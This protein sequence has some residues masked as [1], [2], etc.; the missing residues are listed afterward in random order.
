MKAVITGGAGFIGGHLAERLVSE[1]LDVHVI[2]DFSSGFRSN[3]G[4]VESK[5][6]L[7]SGSILDG[8]LLS[9]AMDGAGAVFHLA[10]IAS[11]PQCTEHPV[12]SHHVNVTGMVL[13][14]EQA[15]K[16]RSRVVFSSSSAIYGDGPEPVKTEDLKPRPLT[17]YA[18]HKLAGEHYLQSYCRLHDLEG[19]ALRYFNV[20]GK[21]Q[22]PNSDYAA[23]I[24][25]FFQRALNHQNL[26]V[27]GTGEQT[28]DFVH[29]HDVVHANF[30]AMTAAD[31]DGSAM[32][33]G[34]GVRTDL[35]T[36]G[37]AIIAATGNEVDIDFAPA[38]AGDILHSCCDPSLARTRLRWEANYTLESGLSEY[39]SES[40][41][42]RSAQEA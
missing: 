11:V 38:R 7:H 33:I 17:P 5:L 19:F 28:R 15:R 9:R 42:G 23:V 27:F 32:N 37:R 20:F 34:L 10:A 14:L 4:R 29:V 18:I 41:P 21:R 31:A 24:P 16:N 22:N 13:V 39:L 1:G 26:T 30:L 2:D 35:I 25:K 40:H 6:T 36:L 8:D 12:E 3:L